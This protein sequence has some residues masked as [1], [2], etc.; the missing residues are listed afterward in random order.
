[1]NPDFAIILNF[2]TTSD[3]D[4]DFLVKT[5]RSIGA[6]AVMSSD[7][8]AFKKACE[9]YTIFLADEQAGLAVT[10]VKVS[11]T[12]VNNRKNGEATIINIPVN[13]GKFD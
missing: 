3:F 1:M 5:A 9:K 11:D 8:A 7:P 13:D 6:R 4:A 2:K 12:L 10:S